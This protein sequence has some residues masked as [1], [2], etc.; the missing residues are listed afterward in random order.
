LAAKP[1]RLEES[2]KI[3]KEIKKVVYILINVQSN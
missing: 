1:V 2:G 3:E